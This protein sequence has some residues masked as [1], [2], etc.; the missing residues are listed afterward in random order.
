MARKLSKSPLAS[1]IVKLR[2]SKK[3]SQAELAHRVG[4]HLN[5]IK[6]IEGSHNEGTH[7][8]RVAIAQALGVGVSELYA[9][10][11]GAATPPH[12]DLDWKEIARLL[13]GYAGA[14]RGPQLLALYLL[15]G[16]ETYMAEFEK[17]PD[18]PRFA[19]MLRKIL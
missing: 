10:G 1:N 17:L 18:G 3:W 14:S 4:V 8:T 2:H 19:S 11:S 16:D 6:N 13:Q 9:D 12:S 7:E 15:L 5:T